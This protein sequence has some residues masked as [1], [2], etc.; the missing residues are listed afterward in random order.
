MK[1][2]PTFRTHP[3]P[4]T[5]TLQI[6]EFGIFF[7]TPWN[8]AVAPLPKVG[9]FLK[10]FILFL[11]KVFKSLV[12]SVCLENSRSKGGPLPVQTWPRPQTWTSQP[13]TEL[14]PT[15]GPHLF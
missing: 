11:Q 13:W 1:E 7:S 14:P 12:F 15:P 6:L 5:K 10:V 4:Q 8:M 9:V 3:G 2:V